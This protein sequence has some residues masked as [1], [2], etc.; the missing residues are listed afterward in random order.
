M[1]QIEEGYRSWSVRDSNIELCRKLGIIKPSGEDLTNSVEYGLGWVNPAAMLGI[2]PTHTKFYFY[3]QLLRFPCSGNENEWN[4]TSKTG[5]LSM[6][7]AI[8]GQGS[9]ESVELGELIEYLT[10]IHCG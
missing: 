1:E 10:V 5:I 6:P 7:L 8:S 3:C 4:G 2:D 9:T